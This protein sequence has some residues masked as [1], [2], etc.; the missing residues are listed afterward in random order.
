MRLLEDLLF[1]GRRLGHGRALHDPVND[2]LP[3]RRCASAQGT[4]SGSRALSAVRSIPCC[5]AAAKRR[6][7]SR[8]NA[9]SRRNSSTYAWTSVP[10]RR[11]SP[12]LRRPIRTSGCYHRIHV[13]DCPC[14]L[15]RMATV[16]TGSGQQS[17][18]CPVKSRSALQQGRCVLKLFVVM[19]VLRWLLQI[20]DSIACSCI[21]RPF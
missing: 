19:C 4:T 18:F 16:S 3:G 6:A 13:T 20:L 5:S 10:A 9:W 17:K 11:H 2:R 21:L 7:G 12:A 15:G 8:S 1:F 14:G